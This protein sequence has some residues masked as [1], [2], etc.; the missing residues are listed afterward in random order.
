MK[1]SLKKAD[2]EI[3]ELS[4]VLNFIRELSAHYQPILYS[5]RKEYRQRLGLSEDTNDKWWDEITSEKLEDEGI[6]GDIVINKN[7]DILFY[8]VALYE[9]YLQIGFIGNNDI[10]DFDSFFTTVS[11]IAKKYFG[12][13]TNW[14][15]KEYD[16]ETK[17]AIDDQSIICEPT[18][19]ETELSII[20][21]DEKKRDFL[22]KIK[23]ITSASITKIFPKDELKSLA[24]IIDEFTDRNVITKDFVV[25]CSKTGQPILKV[26]S[27]SALEETPQGANKC[28]IC[29]NPLS[30][31]ILDEIVSCSP[32]G[33][34]IIEHSYWLQVRIL[35]AL[36]KIGIKS[37]EVRI[38]TSDNDI[39]YL[40][41]VINGQSFIFVLADN[42]ITIEDIYKIKLYVESYNIDNVLL[43]STKNIPL[44]IKKYIENS[45]TED[46]S[47]NFIE[48][49]N[50]IDDTIELFII[51]RCSA[52]ISKLLNSF[53][54]F[55]Q[56]K[57]NEL[58]IESITNAI[59]TVQKTN[60]ADN[61]EAEEVVEELPV[62]EE[63][64]V[65]KG[66]KNKKT[67]DII[68]L[69]V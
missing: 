56:V 62:V 21:E 53:I 36:E 68:E 2:F 10:D 30:K 4:A 42:K 52:Y 46:V 13:N 39:I 38:W 43:I 50:S 47:F 1:I 9:K 18:S 23:D 45:S 16:Q 58:V 29:G 15:L 48:S 40:F 37:E 28:L 69:D 44:V 11:D 12:E 41:S 24:E 22:M 17:H 34:K 66:K 64:H 31:E 54:S 63:V 67:P 7:K 5:I 49:L 19:E 57:I 65:K 35:H 25:L 60:K 61:V 27:R 32:S 3:M 14:I 8:K 33:K 59:P 20:L 51:E 6:F 26:S 55:T